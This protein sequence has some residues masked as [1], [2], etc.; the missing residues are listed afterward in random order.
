MPNSRN[1]RQVKHE[2]PLRGE[3]FSAEH[4]WLHAEQLAARHVVRRGGADRRLVDRFEDNSRFIAGSYRAIIETVRNNEPL[5]PDAEWLV[6]NYY[7]VE[8]QLREIREDLPRQFYLELPKLVDGPFA[9]SPRVHELAF[10]LVLHTDSSLD[11]EL[12]G[13]FITAYQRKTTL[14]SGE[15]WAVPIMLRLV[16]VENLRRLCN[17]MLLT[18]ESQPH[19][20]RILNQWQADVT[21]VTRLD[22]DEDCSVI[23]EI[24]ELLAASNL[25]HHGAGD[26]ELFDRLGLTQEMVDEC[27]RKEQQRLAANQVS[28]GNSITSMRLLTALDW[29]LFFER[30]SLVEQTLRQDPAGVYPL[31][32]FATRDQY[33]HEIERIAKHGDHDETHVAAAALRHASSDRANRT[34]DGPQ[35]HVGFFVMGAGQ[36]ELEQ[37]FNYRPKFKERLVRGVQRHAAGLYLGGIAL[38][39]AVLSASISGAALMAGNSVLACVLL[40]LLSMLPVSE[41]AVGLV[42]FLVTIFIRPRLLPKLDFSDGVP[43]RWQTLVVMPT[44]LTSKEAVRQ[45]LERLEIH[46][47]A[48]PES[49]LIFALLSDFVDSSDEETDEDR[50]LLAHA[51]AGI[52]SLNDRHS[53]DSEQRFFLLHRRRQWN[54]VEKV[55]M[56]WERKRGK[57]LEL[58]RLLRGDS[59]TSF[60]ITTDE[61]AR[62]A[63]VKFVITLDSDTRLPHAVARRLA[64]TLAH[65]LN[66]PHFDGAAHRVT[67]GYGV[68]Q[69]RVSVSLASANRSLFARIFSNSGGLDPYCTAVSDVYQ[70]LFGEGSYTGKG[71]YDVD[72]FITATKDTFPPNQILSHDLI[73]GCYARVGSVSD[74]ELFDEYPTRVDVEARRQHRWIRGDWQILPWLFPHVPTPQGRQRNPLNALSRWKVFDNLRRSL[75]PI[76]LVALC[77]A[78]WLIFANAATIATIA[79]VVALTSPFFFHMLAVIVTWRPGQYWRQQFRD[80]VPTVGRTLA[81]CLLALMQLPFRAYYTTDAV[82]RTLYRL[83]VSRR[84]LLEWETAD[85]AERRL[86]NTQ[87][88]LIVSM[89]WIP[90]ACLVVAALLPA[91]V[92]PAALP[93]LALWFVSPAVAFVLSRP[94]ISAPEPISIEE[95]RSLRRIA[96]R[97]WAFFEEFVGA[98][99]NWLPPDNYQEFPRPKVA[100]RISPTNEGLF[101]VSTIAAR[102]FGYLGANQLAQILQRNLDHWT[103]LDKYCGHFYNWYDT[104]T[105]DPLPPRYVSTADSGNLAACFLTA[106]QAMEDIVAAPL[107]GPFVAEG[108]MDSVRLVEEALGRLQPRGARFVSQALAALDAALVDLRK[109]VEPPPADIGKWREMAENLTTESGRLPS[110]LHDF[111]TSLGLK[112]SELSSKLRCLQN[113]IAGVHHDIESMLPWARC[114]R[115]GGKVEIDGR[116]VMPSPIVDP[117]WN[118]AWEKLLGELRASPTLHHLSRLSNRISPTLD[119]LRTQLESGTVAASEA[120]AIQA[121]LE[122]LGA[123]VLQGTEQAQNCYD[124]FLA[125]GRRYEALAKEM[126]FTLLYNPQRR[127]FA[128]G[129]NLE[130]GRLDRAHYDML[131]SEARIASLVAIAKSDTEHRHW[132]QLGRALT[133]TPSGGVGLLSW[134]GTMFEFLMPTLFTRDVP[135]SLLE[136]SCEAAVARQIAYGRQR[137]VPW[138][139]SESAFSAQ[140]ANGDYHYQSFGVPGLGLKRGLGKDLVVSPYSTA[141]ALPVRPEAAIANFQALAG[142]GAEGPWGFYDAL[143]YTPERVPAGERRVIVFCYMAHHQGMIM[144]AIANFLRDQAMQRRFQRQPLVRS[145]DL[146]LQERIPVAVLHFN[147]PEDAAVSVPSIPITTGPVSRR[148]STPHTVVPRA[149]LLSNGEYSVMVSNSG[150]GYSRYRDLAITRWRADTTRDDMGQFV[151]L[152]DLNSKKVWSAAYHPMQT[153]PDAYE[154]T[155]SIDKAEFRRRDGSLETHLEIAVSTEK[156]AEVRQ[157]TVTNHGRRPATLDITSYAELVLCAARADSAHPAFNKLFV[158]TEFLG[159]C[160]ALIARR[161]PREN[162]AEVPWAVHVLAAQ[163]SSLEQLQFETD[164]ARFLGRGRTTASPAAL[165]PDAVLSGTIGPVLDPIF[166]L[167]GR[168]HIAPDESASLA[169]MTGYAASRDEALQLADQFRDPRLVLRTFE[170][171][172]AQSQVELRHLHVSPTSL[173]LYQRL[174]S[175]LLYPDPS[176][177]ASPSVLKANRLGQ[178]SLWRHGVSGDDPIILL[179]VSKPDHRSLMRELL[180]A[181]EFWNTHGLKADLV[182]IN[183]HPSGYFDQFQEQLLELI[184]T[185]SRMPLTR[186]GGIYLLRAA[187]MSPEEMLLFQE[188]A[189]ISLQGDNGPLAR[190]VETSMVTPPAE[191]PKLRAARGAIAPDQS[192]DGKLLAPVPPLE[193]AQPLG[194]F[195][196]G[197]DYVIQLKSDKRAPAPWSNVIANPNFGFLITESGSGYTWAGNSRENKLTSW[198]NDPVSDP[199][200]EVLYLRDEESGAVWTPTPL[201]IRD[202]SEYR[203]VHG[204]GHSQFAHVA[205]GIHSDFTVSLAPQDAVK[206]ACL[207]LRNTTDRPRNL[208]ATYFVEW[209]L[210]VTR[211][212]SQM[213][214]YT[215]RDETTG[216]LTAQNSYNEEFPDQIAF[217]H[218]LGGADS[219]TGDRTEFIGRNGN[220]QVPAAMRRMDLSS[221]TGAGFDPCGAVQKKL[222]LLPGQELEVIFLL[223]WTD[224]TKA[225]ADVLSAYATRDHVHQAIEKTIQFWTDT[226]QTIEIQTPNR[227]FDMLV[228]HWLL[229]QTLSCRIWARSAFYQSGGAFG[230]RDQ[231][232]DVMA[233]VYSL[234]Q[235]ARQVI[236]LAASRQFEEGDVQHWWHP[237][238]GRGIRTRFRDDFLWLPFVTSHYVAIT[239]DTAI[240]NEPI[241]YLHSQL[242]EAHEDER[243]ELPEI[244]PLTEDLYSHCLRAIDH[245]FRTGSHGLPL[246]GCGDWNDGMNRVGAG[247]KGE[248]VWLAWFLRVV[249]QQFLPF[250]RSRGDAQRAA[251]YAHQADQLLQAA[252][253]N[254]WDGQWY[255]R[256]YFDDGTPLGSTQNDECQI[257]SLVQSWS[258]IAGGDP[259]RTR[260]AMQA[261]KER[262]VRRDERFVQLLDPPFDKTSLDPGYIKGYPPGIR[263]NG[264]QYTHAAAWFIQALTMLG[265]GTEAAEA[266][267]LLNP[268]RSSSPSGGA[269]Y[270]VEP[271]VVAADVYSTPP[272]V[273][274]GGWTWYTGSAGWMY[275]V[276]IEY[277]L[278]LRLRHDRLTLAPC[279][280]AGWPSFELRLRRGST[281]WTIRVENPDGL[282]HGVTQVMFDGRHAPSAEIPLDDDGS[283]HQV[284]IV[285]G[286]SEDALNRRGNGEATLANYEPNSIVPG[287]TRHFA[288]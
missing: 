157:I 66:R 88:S 53:V 277:I 151:Y 67:R 142:Q 89:S 81:Q 47:L 216:A 196:S 141:L 92:R 170:M 273:G 150:G 115:A 146:L 240:L 252:E 77:L 74:V 13:G 173:Q 22:T 11:E 85:A 96:R 242:L 186:P 42:N 220:T 162:G 110:L 9:G 248:S 251:A 174:A 183:E 5:A 210:S 8:E 120:Q 100:H 236:L 179:R 257:D 144:A 38:V 104:T 212:S 54:A 114:L 60:A 61:R 32:D 48:N 52:R 37:E 201:P 24:F 207:K 126:D 197:G 90:L 55:W 288:E 130:D 12:I 87:A 260:T 122:Q 34:Q 268:I 184:S 72:A 106:Q 31:M 206:F 99:D 233:L 226:R 218:V 23:V 160:P 225:V 169:F 227:A 94:Q 244:S 164:R 194:G 62:L 2:T 33:R 191:R 59:G 105:L 167:R 249:L 80:T 156:T 57:L 117:D 182:I 181:H 224:G 4:L 40:G 282:E 44:L 49:G 133:E 70:D 211:D 239:G 46:C 43:S 7:I 93:V 134:G 121:W 63:G 155:Y 264:G 284:Q 158:E 276:A 83:F 28:I 108:V 286:R 234:P 280:P 128:V 178:R 148:I 255:R 16:L 259:D 50:N 91:G 25:I 30:V 215:S 250:V 263:E 147:P 101:V 271:Y 84:K 138:G 270:R 26:H 279:I 135:G 230:F 272:H 231:L 145:T 256:A 177:R 27:I 217:L 71:I 125:L 153:E 205:H 113:T 172:W 195:K 3:P 124:C 41:L 68:L 116:P 223:G 238:S 102:D 232:Q 58:N 132:F 287:N 192:A 149:H 17:Q 228:N 253:Q 119:A 98:E 189:A 187:Q 258:V 163:P 269:N 161:R 261:V 237:P 118:T 75:V 131:A 185:T 123:L 175:A 95:R 65:P 152:R 111:E 266:F 159:D 176:L 20:Q 76:S 64:G 18:R 219:V 193:F 19:A 139:I 281:A 245:G 171:A 166:S 107:V 221:R 154:V 82:V 140:A 204:R 180:Y 198:S 35:Q 275:R 222:K 265:N 247:G 127:L 69:P 10:E 202:K 274:R 214:V 21:S 285:L 200:S 73:E 97:T 267:D 86:K 165:D 246:M 79:A 208:S 188:V 209:V 262:L 254:A 278:G 136:R 213:H 45:L 14:T 283:P 129:F 199:P 78:G 15:L 56:G 243:Y 168:L 36:R 235:V 39:T 6:D 109:L 203:I 190:Q 1:A 137:D 29:A 51:I 229:Y 112:A 103:K 241:S 143:D